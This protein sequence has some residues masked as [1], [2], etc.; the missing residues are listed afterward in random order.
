[1]EPGTSYFSIF[2][3]YKWP[4]SSPNSNVLPFIT[5]E[6]VMAELSI[7]N[8]KTFYNKK[9]RCYLK[10]AMWFDLEVYKQYY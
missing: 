6:D 10:V 5:G 1:M 3:E 9:T 7:T 8:R 2:S 4:E